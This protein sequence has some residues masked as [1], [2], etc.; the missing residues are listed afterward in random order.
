MAWVAPNG[1]LLAYPFQYFMLFKILYHIDQD[2][3]IIY[4]IDL[5]IHIKKNLWVKTQY[6]YLN[7]KHKGNWSY[8]MDSKGFDWKG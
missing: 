5:Y 1:R 4:F 8:P 2:I 6:I 3:E 7:K